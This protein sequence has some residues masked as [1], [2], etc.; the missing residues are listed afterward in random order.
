M[1]KKE[2]NLNKKREELI[3]KLQE[4]YP[5]ISWHNIFCLINEQDKEF[6]RLLKDEIYGYPVEF[7]LESETEANAKDLLNDI[8]QRIDKLA[9]PKFA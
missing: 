6:I 2:F 3:E 9:G 7:I 1:E 8:V 4:E 5:K